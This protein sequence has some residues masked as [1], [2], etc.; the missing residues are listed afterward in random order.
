VVEPF[1]LAIIGGGPAGYVAALRAAQMDA[2]VVLIERASLGGTCL[3]WGCIP[4]KALIRSAE[5]LLDAR[6]ASELGVDIAGNPTANLPRMMARKNEVVKTL[7]AGVEGLLTAGKVTLLRGE[8]RL[9]SQEEGSWKLAVGGDHYDARR[10]ILASGSVPARIPVPGNDLPGVITSTEAL[11]LAAIPP[12]IVI[13]GGNVIGLEFACLF[14]ALG[15][16]VTILEMLPTLLPNSD[17]RFAAR[18]LGLLRGRGVTVSLGAR[19]IGIEQAEAGLVVRYQTSQAEATASGDLVLLA[20]GQRPLTE[21]LGLDTAGVTMNRRAIAVNEYLETNLPGLYA[22]GDCTGGMMLA[23]VASHAGIVA[24]ENALGKHRAMD[25]A[26]VPACI[27]TMPE[28]ASVGLTERQAKESGRAVTVGRFPFA[29]L[30][31]ALAMGETE[32]QVRLI[33]E[34]GSSTVL[35]MHV[36]GPHASDLIAEGALA[37]RLGLTA[38][39]LA[40]TIHAHPTLP[41]ATAEAALAVY[42]EAIHQRKA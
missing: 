40:D 11:S 15:S 32:G 9:A 12:S 25:L 6:N 38:R 37:V 14:W 31:R 42:G 41:E 27:F 23:H 33:C 1:D 21:N 22:A 30:G 19:V 8:A 36:M 7:V 28:I 24:T 4:T 39:D 29:A 20:T 16:K 10:V 18:M 26:A 13:A 5:A 3:N 17:E 2:R 34:T 35:G